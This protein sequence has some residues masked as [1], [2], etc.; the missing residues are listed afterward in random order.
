MVSDVE[1]V[2]LDIPLPVSNLQLR[3]RSDLPSRNP[4]LNADHLVPLF[5]L[6]NPASSGYDELVI[7]RYRYIDPEGLDAIDGGQPVLWDVMGVADDDSGSVVSDYSSRSPSTRGSKGKGPLMALLAP[8]PIDV[9]ESQLFETL[10]Q[11]A[12]PPPSS[13]AS[14]P[15]LRQSPVL[16]T[17]FSKPPPPHTGS[18][19]LGSPAQSRTLSYRSATPKNMFRGPLMSQQLE[20]VISHPIANPLTLSSPTVGS[21]RHNHHRQLLL[22][23]LL[24]S[25]SSYRPVNLATIKKNINLRPGEGERLNYVNRVRRTHGTAYNETE[26]GKWKLPIGIMPVDKSALAKNANGKYMRLAGPQANLRKAKTLGVELK[27]GHLKQK[28]LAGEIDERDLELPTM[29][30]GGPQ[31]TQP[32][33]EGVKLLGLLISTLKRSETMMLTVTSGTSHS[34]DTGSSA[35][36]VSL[37]SLGSLQEEFDKGYY[38]H[39]AYDEDDEDEDGPSTGHKGLVLANP[40]TDSD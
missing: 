36:S 38:Q 28:L 10:L 1:T 39:P 22:I 6:P 21:P 3:E 35:L 34:L 2:P 24:F 7:D 14:P 17:P 37:G 20:H 15:K 25:S 18:A 11:L 31:A 12:S 16:A 19:S 5:P 40:D 27:H 4:F 23:S 29:V 9:D 26:P 30:I 32:R 13:L 33:V 8:Y